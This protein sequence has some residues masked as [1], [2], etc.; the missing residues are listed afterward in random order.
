MYLAYPPP[1]DEEQVRGYEA[2]RNHMR[3]VVERYPD[4]FRMRKKRANSSRPAVRRG[5][6]DPLR[7]KKRQPGGKNTQTAAPAVPEERR[8]GPEA[9]LRELLAE[10]R[11][12]GITME[13]LA[14][15]AGYSERTLRR[16][17]KTPGTLPLEEFCRIVRAA[18]GMCT[19]GGRNG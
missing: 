18:K 15:R 17:L 14:E 4:R 8:D 2:L 6:E 16:R 10:A 7:L 11:Q 9:L 13:I 12:R 3:G 19:V 5:Q 1:D